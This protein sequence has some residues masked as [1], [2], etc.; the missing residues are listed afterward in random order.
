MHKAFHPVGSTKNA[1]TLNQVGDAK[2]N[3]KLAL[4]SYAA[5]AR[6]R[7]RH[8]RKHRRFAYAAH[9][10]GV[11]GQEDATMVA[12]AGTHTNEGGAART[13]AYLLH[14]IRLMYGGGGGGGAISFSRAG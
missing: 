12:A 5:A 1:E 8:P 3:R 4:H 2:S 13:R 6:P 10:R 11:N 7:V 9:L 14:G